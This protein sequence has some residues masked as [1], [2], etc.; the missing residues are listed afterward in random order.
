MVGCVRESGVWQTRGSTPLLIASHNGHV[1]VARALVGAGA[2]VNQA[3]V[4]DDCVGSSC[5]VVRE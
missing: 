2:A 4:R 1:E 5:S 3:M